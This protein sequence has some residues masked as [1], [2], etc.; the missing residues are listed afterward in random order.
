MPAGGRA[1]VPQIRFGLFQRIL[2]VVVAI[3]ALALALAT[4]FGGPRPVAAQD[5]V[6]GMGFRIGLPA[7]VFSDPEGHQRVMYADSA[8]SL[9][10]T[11]PVRKARV[12]PNREPVYVNGRPIA[13]CCSPCPSVFSQNPERYLREMKVS[14]RCPVRPARR[15]IFDSSL[16]MMLNQDIYFFSSMTAMKLFRKDPL[17]YCG[18]L[19]DPVSRDRFLPTKAS[20]HVT[21]RGRDY[22]FAADSTLARFQEQP[23]RFY[24]RLAG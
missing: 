1:L 6:G 18:T 14:V 2:I 11:C 12:D 4:L 24:E 22:Y 9:N 3:L 19:T 21:F 13:F 23:E 17:R 15:A 10:T 16:R 7:Y 8:I 20:P 5:D